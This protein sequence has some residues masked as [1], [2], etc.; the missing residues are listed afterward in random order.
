MFNF[1]IVYGQQF[2]NY[3]KNTIN[4]EKYTVNN[5]LIDTVK[6]INHL[7]SS[8]INE[9]IETNYS[10]AF[11]YAGEALFLA[12]QLQNDVL[13]AKSHKVY[14]VL[15][16]LF[17]QDELA[18][19]HFKKSMRLYERGV[20]DNQLES[21]VLFKPYYN[22]VLY[23]QRTK[24]NDSLKKYIKKCE[25][26]IDNYKMSKIH[27]VFLNEKKASICVR[28]NETNK[29]KALLKSSVET[30]ELLEYDEKNKVYKSFL[31]ILYTTLGDI[32]REEGKQKE[33]IIYFKK[34][35]GVD[36]VNNEHTFYLSYVYLRYANSLLS[37]NQPKEAYLNLM[38]SKQ[39]ND[40]YLNPRNESN[41]D[42]LTIKNRYYEQI[43]VQKELLNK[44]RFELSDKN[45]KLL[46]FRI[47]LFLIV[48][49]FLLV[50]GIFIYRVK[51][52]NFKKE[53]KL[54]SQ[55]L[56]AINKE[57]TISTLALIEKEEL[58]KKLKDHLK[59]T[60]QDTKTKSLL[61]TIDTRSNNL[62]ESFNSR[63]KAQNKGFYE[64]LQ[65]KTPNLS[66]ADLKLCALIKL[67]FTGKEMA[68]LLGISLGSVH[69]ARH[70]LRKKMNLE[71]EVNLTSFINSL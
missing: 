57:L 33:A 42:F 54:S 60:S 45:Q 12:E 4:I 13:I 27:H 8:S 7:L 18:G 36:D 44:Q 34:A 29:A 70:R 48:S 15:N 64:R 3:Q 50:L 67:N 56:E 39:I 31:I 9:R 37:L 22:M 65:V 17:K 46:R 6:I 26:V 49:F 63:F 68:Y 40:K 24:N 35:I 59:T 58:I 10:T 66:A 55:S 20:R 53:Q 28:N 51:N 41:Q 38:L 11:N 32:Y 16:Y 71:R 14:G 2:S 62:W 21:T 69:V 23:Y 1:N 61:K 30:L 5:K 47:Y 19:D 43:G 52:T 25:S